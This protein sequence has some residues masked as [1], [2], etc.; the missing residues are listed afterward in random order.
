MNQSSDGTLYVWNFG[1]GTT[2][3]DENPTHTYDFDFLLQNPT[4]TVTLT[5]TGAEGC[6]DSYSLE[7]SMIYISVS[8]LQNAFSVVAYPNPVKNHVTLV[9]PDHVEQIMICDLVGKTVAQV[10]TMSRGTVDI[11]LSSLASGQYQVRAVSAQGTS[12]LKLI[13]I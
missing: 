11:D 1:D 10:S 6:T 9:V 5:V 13:K 8:E 12:V 3:F 2:S 7:L 4:V